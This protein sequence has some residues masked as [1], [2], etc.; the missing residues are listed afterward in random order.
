[1]N[2][3]G[4]R[5]F[6]LAGNTI[7]DTN[8]T[9]QVQAAR[10]GT[11]DAWDGLFRRYQLPL[12][13]YVRELVRD[14]EASLDIIQETFVNASRHLDSL[15]DDAKFGSW[16]FG[17]ARQKCIHHWRRAGRDERVFSSELP[18]DAAAGSNGENPGAFL[19]KREREDEFIAAL[20]QLPVPHRE[21]VTL[22]FLEEFPLDEIATLTGVPVGTVKSRLH[23]AKKKL[24][25]LLEEKS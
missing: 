17:I 8:M 24:R 11:R 19:V 15:R 14:R 7:V 10:N 12:F 5:A 25:E 2:L 21:A 18:D 16:L 9:A 23:H 6:Y 3:R 1:L 13:T 22:H 4:L 20:E